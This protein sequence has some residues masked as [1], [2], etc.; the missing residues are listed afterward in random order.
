MI[1]ALRRSAWPKKFGTCCSA[2]LDTIPP[3]TIRGNPPEE[4]VQTQGKGPWSAGDDQEPSCG[5]AITTRPR[6]CPTVRIG[7]GQRQ[8]R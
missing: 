8:G 3:F 4:L 2:V 7:R 1:S 5:H 6:D